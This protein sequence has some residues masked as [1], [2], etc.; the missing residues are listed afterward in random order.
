MNVK[1]REKRLQ[2][3]RQQT[4]TLLAEKLKDVR[5][6]KL[7]DIKEIVYEL[8]V[9]QIELEMQNE[10]LRR[11]QIELQESQNKYLGLYNSAPTGYFTLDKDGVIL[12]VNTTG[13]E[14]FGTDKSKLI[15]TKFT[16]L[17]SPESQ[18]TF[19]LHC[20]KLFKTSARQSCEITFLKTDGSLFY[21]H[22]DSIFNSRVSGN[23]NQHR[24]IV[25]DISD[26]KRAENELRKFKAI[27][28]K[29]GYGIS[30]VDLEGN[31]SYVNTSYAR[32]H[33]Y[34]PD[35]V[36]GKHF[37]IFHS[38]QQMENVNR[39]LDQLKREGS[40]IAEEVWHKKKDG[41][42]FPTMMNGT[43]IKDENEVPL[44]M[45]GTAIDIS[46]R[47]RVEE[48][49]REVETLKEID[50][51]RT[52]LLANIS[53]EL[54]TP[55]TSIK[56][57]TTMI[58]EYDKKLSN[59]EKR[60]YLKTVDLSTDRL[61][62]LIDQLLDMSRLDAGVLTVDNKPANISKLVQDVVNEAQFR[63]PDHRLLLDLP[64]D[65]PMLN[66]DARRTR[67]VLENL[68]DN[69]VKYSQANTEIK[70]AVQLDENEVLISVADEGI[71]ILP[72]ELSMVFDRFF[73]SRRRQVRGKQ[74][75]GL[76]LPICKKLI[77]TQGGKIWIESEDGK[78][79]TC[80]FTLPLS[81]LPGHKNTGN[82]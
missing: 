8:Q 32:M 17:I 59:K 52:E 16:H 70:I 33:G 13:A 78:G 31:N 27:S 57:F 64:G 35:E 75:V 37:S 74:G 12:E 14:L 6:M 15:G 60:N 55:L 2:E 46:E 40:Y 1:A 34:L 36:I 28:D 42:E 61:L 47:K 72:E 80:F 56:G 30:I 58:L 50:R 45:A 71:G 23:L 24:M 9:H 65:L 73:R 5:E 3:L 82:S 48:K 11:I 67:Q 53:H 7:E 76:G 41:T 38:Q 79:T 44:F 39:L 29:A 51:L 54:R 25:M 63:L 20:K 4:E 62:E 22:V 10:E 66:I 77:E 26:L 21:A 81:K 69:A 68:I 18:D 49:A 43:L 19:Y